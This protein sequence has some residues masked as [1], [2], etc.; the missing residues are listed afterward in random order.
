MQ[1]IT[2][3]KKKKDDLFFFDQKFNKIIH[4]KQAVVLPFVVE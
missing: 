1:Q 4:F 3:K 2:V